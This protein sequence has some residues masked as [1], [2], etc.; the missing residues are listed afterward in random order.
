M[1]LLLSSERRSGLE[2]VTV[3]HAHVQSMVVFVSWR[4]VVL[5]FLRV[6]QPVEQ[7]NSKL[8]LDTVKSL[9]YTHLH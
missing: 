4:I 6:V 7:S 9:D 3:V 2:K 8:F 1:A 5:M